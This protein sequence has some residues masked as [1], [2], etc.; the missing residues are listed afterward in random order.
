MPILIIAESNWEICYM[1]DNE[2]G[3]PMILWLTKEGTAEAH[4]EWLE[5][6]PGDPWELLSG[7]G[8]RFKEANDL[9]GLRAGGGEPT[10]IEMRA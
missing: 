2:P 7:L 8:Y 4:A 1:G 3:K 6:E 9:R 10:E 5:N